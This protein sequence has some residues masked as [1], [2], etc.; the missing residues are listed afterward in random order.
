MRESIKIVVWPRG[1]QE[2]PDGK[3]YRY[4]V[5]GM[6]VTDQPLPN[7]EALLNGPGIG[8]TVIEHTTQVAQ[9]GPLLDT[10]PLRSPN[11]VLGDATNVL[12]SL[13]RI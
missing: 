13:K 6:V 10:L 1:P 7:L 3:N 5:V 4:V 2:G 9:L 12:L 8:E 11:V